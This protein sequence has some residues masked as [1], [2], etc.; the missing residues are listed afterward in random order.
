MVYA[1]VLTAAAVV[2]LVVAERQR[3]LNRPMPLVWVF[4]P[5]A[6][7]GFLLTA[8]SAGALHSTF[9][10]MMLA[11]LSCGAVGDVLLIPRDNEK[12]FLLGMGIFLVGHLCYVAAFLSRGVAPAG[13]FAA[14]AVML[15]VGTA[16]LIWLWS[17][18]KGVMRPMLIAYVAV[19]SA[20]VA[21]A[22]GASTHRDTAQFAT[23]AA[24]FIVADIMTARQRFVRRQFINKVIALPLY[25]S[26]Q[27]L[28]AVGAGG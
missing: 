24:L 23:A 3:A 18:A 11:A 9:G 20:M 4:K 22:A 13:A 17:C 27:L 19:F 8:F 7:I 2:A 15:V 6:S 26:A 5:L 28:F 1:I 21:A 16:V 10:L 14:I 25:Y 12:A